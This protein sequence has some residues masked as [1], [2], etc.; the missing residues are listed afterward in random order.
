MAFNILFNQFW[1]YGIGCGIICGRH[2]KIFYK[3]YGVFAIRLCCR[4]VHGNL[5]VVD[6]IISDDVQQVY[7][8]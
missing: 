3:R 7:L 4:I 1:L 5:I 2:M 8:L 6:I